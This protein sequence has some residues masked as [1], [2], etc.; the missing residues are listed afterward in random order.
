MQLFMGSIDC[1]YFGDLQLFSL[2]DTSIIQIF[3]N[4]KTD[5]TLVHRVCVS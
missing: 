1:G 2:T 3:D 4:K 5:F